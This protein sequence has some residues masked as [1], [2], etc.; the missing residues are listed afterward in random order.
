MRS[1]YV[2]FLPP[3]CALKPVHAFPK[4]P[5]ILL[6]ALH[7]SLPQKYLTYFVD[8]GSKLLLSVK[9]LHLPHPTF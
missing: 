5:H 3:M 1:L 4:H 6:F 9:S 7:C 8:H 2:M